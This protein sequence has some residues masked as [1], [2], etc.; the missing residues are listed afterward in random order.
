MAR[1]FVIRPFGIKQD[2]SGQQIDFERIHAELI[3]PALIAS[4]L[5][6]SATGE[7]V[8]SGNIRE[9]MFALI[10]EADIVIC[11][12]SIHNANVFYELG[13]RHALR[14][15]WTVLIRGESTQDAHP[16]DLLTDRYLVYDIYNPGASKSALIEVITASMKSNRPTDSPIFQMVPS[17]PEADPSAVQIVPFDFRE[18]VHRARSAS[19]KGRGW[20]RLLSEEVRDRRFAWEGLKLVASAQWGIKDYEGAR[21]SWE[22]IKEIYP[23]DIAANLALANVY[24]R[25]YRSEKR[26]ELLQDSDNAIMRVLNAPSAS[27]RQRAEAQAL[28]GRNQKTRWRLEFLDHDMGAQR[29]EDAMNRSLI[30]AYENY[31]KAFFQDLNHFHPGLSALQMGTILLGLSENDAWYDAFDD[32]A[33]AD[34]YK[35]RLEDEVQALRALVPATVEAARVRLSKSDPERMWVEISAADVLFLTTERTRRVLG[36]YRHAI[37]LDMPFAWDAARGQLQLYEDLGIK[38][39]LASEI[40]KVMDGLFEARGLEATTMLRHLVLFA[41]HQI[42]D[43]ARTQPR[44]PADAEKRARAMIFEAVADLKDGDD[45]L[46]ALASAASGADI[47][48]HEVCTELGIVSTVCL[49]M[50]ANE[51]SSFAFGYYLDK[52]RTRFLDLLEHHEVLEL[53]DRA[54][55]PNWLSDAQIDPW[56]RGNR[57]V[58][59]M[60]LSGGADRITLI[61]LWDGKEYDDT[62]GGTAQMVK[63]SRDA[64]IVQLVHLD[65]TQLLPL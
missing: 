59:E 6:G 33:E 13:I 44:F 23:D 50:P 2:S 7:L 14:R 45:K 41:G 56:E 30:A 42:D 9:D 26:P 39:E 31:H 55:L 43:P 5:G 61:A 53:S 37:P 65:S 17:L 46:E 34:Q 3:Q 19:V 48:F 40:I 36:A 38:A 4:D 11:D 18:E 54:G 57:W 35:R 27:R 16:F 24:E 51:F 64:G 8:E 10:L 12:I 21:R 58:M 60:A 1:A 20:L 25:L 63:L 22:A 32:D 49:P 15:K 52:W 28:A 29:L 62:P 47:L